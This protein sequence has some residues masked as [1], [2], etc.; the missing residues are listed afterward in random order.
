MS[1][2]INKT[3]HNILTV[4][5]HKYCRGEEMCIIYEKDGLSNGTRQYYKPLYLKIP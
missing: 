4:P 2:R 3:P 1:S 5:Y